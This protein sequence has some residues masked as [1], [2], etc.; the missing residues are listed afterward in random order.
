MGPGIDYRE[1]GFAHR[2]L[3]GGVRS[4]GTGGGPQARTAMCAPR[5]RDA[6]S[7]VLVS[8]RADKSLEQVHERRAAMFGRQFIRV[9][10]FITEPGKLLCVE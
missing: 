6:I 1:V 2:W 5:D 8:S 7:V 4:I 3:R 9:D 10:E